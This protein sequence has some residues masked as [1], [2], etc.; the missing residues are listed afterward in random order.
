MRFRLKSGLSLHYRT[1]GIGRTMILIHPIGLNGKFWKPLVKRLNHE[2]RLIVPDIRGHG[3]SDFSADSFD[4]NDMAAD[5]VELT[6]AIGG[7]QSPIIV[8]CSMGGMIAQGFALQAPELTAGLVLAN[9]SHI[10]DAKGR[11]AIEERA[12]ATELGMSNVTDTTLL[13]WFDDAFRK[14]NPKVIEEVREWLLS[15]DPVVHAATWRAMRD[16]NFGDQLKSIEKPALAIAGIKDRSVSIDQVKQISN[17]IPHCS[18]HE[19]DAGHLSPL[20]L[21]D[22]FALLLREFVTTRVS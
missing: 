8:G 14:A 18:F 17:T 16:L 12:V 15:N 20:E 19:I 4:L 21:P 6:R 9:T 13:R 10:R 3:R 1:Y 2:F 7:S 5:V 22:E 11:A